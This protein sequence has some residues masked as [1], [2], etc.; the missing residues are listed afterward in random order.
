MK[1]GHA[2]GQQRTQGP[3]FQCGGGAHR[4]QRYSYGHLVFS[5]G[6]RVGV[7][8][9]EREACGGGG[10][11]CRRG[12][13]RDKWCVL[14]LLLSPSLFPRSRLLPRP[15]VPGWAGGD[16]CYW[17]WRCR[18][19]ASSG[20]AATSGAGLC[21]QFGHVREDAT[22]EAVRSHRGHGGLQ[23]WRRAA[24]R[25][26]FNDVEP[27]LFGLR[28]LRRRRLRTL[29]LRL[30]RRLLL[31]SVAPHQGHGV[32]AGGAH[33]G[34]G[35]VQSNVCLDEAR[36]RAVRIVRDDP[37]DARDLGGVA[38]GADAAAGERVKD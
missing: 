32:G 4:M 16:R 8:L 38:Q 30:L 35:A 36:A 21:C 34:G 26:Q 5:F 28:L 15:Q 18:C 7:A 29:R 11:G 2:I 19:A 1:P 25:V 17:W 27:V 31:P 14:S 22:E 23:E 13:R 33:H 10:G 24:P 3:A 20:A 12:V 9:V 37:H 6:A